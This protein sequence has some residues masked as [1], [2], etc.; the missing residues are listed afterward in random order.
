MTDPFTPDENDPFGQPTKGAYPT[1]E[2]LEGSLIMF[3]PSK[4]ADMVTNRFYKKEGD[5]THV[6]RLSVDTIVFGPTGV[7]EYSDM[8]W[9]QTAIINA[10]EQALKPGAKP[11]VLGRLVKVP[12]KDTIE[13]LKIENTAEAFAAAREKWLK[14]GGKGPEPRHVW[15]MSEFDADDAQR[16]RDYLKQRA[17]R[18]AASNAARDPFASAPAE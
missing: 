14:G 16:A 11:F 6:A 10:C 17:A 5:A 3:M 9:S 8:Y 15:V 13:K 18:A 1:P 4:P 2:S 12:T 7:E